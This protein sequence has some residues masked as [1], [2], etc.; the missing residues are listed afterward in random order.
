MNIPNL[1]TISRFFLLLI[2]S[3]FIL[4]KDYKISIFFLFLIALSDWLDG[5][6]A[7]RFNQETNLGKTLDPLIDKIFI[8]SSFI[9]LSKQGL[10]PTW[11]VFL[12]IGRD[13]FIILGIFFLI[14]KK[15]VKIISPTYLGKLTLWFQIIC[16]FF[17]ILSKITL[18]S[19]LS[20]IFLSSLRYYLYIF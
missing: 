5:F 1:I 6:L 20:Y 18:I 19:F 11:L 17:A 10:L 7:R 14:V 2:F 9:I 8:I 12:V 15:E 3:H 16:I 13:F 4:E